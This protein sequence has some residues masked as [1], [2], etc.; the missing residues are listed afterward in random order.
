MRRSNGWTFM[1]MLAAATALTGVFASAGAGAAH[2]GGPVAQALLGPPVAVDDNLTT[3]LG[4]PGTVFVLD[5]D[6]D[7]DGDALIV[8]GNT[9][10]P[11]GNAVCDQF[12]Q[13]D[14]TPDG[15]YLGS[16]GFDY[17]VSDG[18]GG[19]DVGTVHVS[20]VANSP[21]VAVDDTLTTKLNT[22]GTAFVLDNDTD[23]DDDTLTVTRNTD[24]PHGTATCGASGSCTYTPDAGYLGSD[25][26]DYT[27]SDGTATDTGTVNV[28][29]VANS[30][31]VAVDDTLTTKQN[32]AKDVFVLENDTDANGDALTVTGNTDP[33]HGTATCNS[34]GSCTYTPDA[35]YL[36][37]DAFDYT[38]SDGTATDTGTVDVTV[39]ANSPPVAVDDTLTTKLNTQRT[40]FVLG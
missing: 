4:T 40:E 32:A 36:G 29:V 10:P 7:P 14:Y 9:D 24:P 26:F 17:T 34:F 31:P 39:V 3:K 20:V 37:P 18:N 13:C 21:P 38:V 19:T 28:T 16:D 2:E 5:N 1:L 23:A 12:G 8:T 6:T 11:H 25:T 35:G 15:G 30:P 33:P 22:Q 27:V